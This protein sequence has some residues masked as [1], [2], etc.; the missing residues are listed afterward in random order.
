MKNSIMTF[1]GNKPHTRTL[2]V[3]LNSHY[4]QLSITEL[5]KEAKVSRPTMFKIVKRLM[6]G[7]IIEKTRMVGN[8]P[9][10]KLS[11]NDLTKNLIALKKSIER[12]ENEQ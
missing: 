10:Y 4:K 1:F 9:M 11:K 2:S 12:K 5:T 7:R 8:S 3:F 6:N